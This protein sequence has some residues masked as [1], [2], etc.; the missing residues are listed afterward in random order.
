MSPTATGMAI[1]AVLALTWIILGFWACF[2]VGLAIALGAGIGRFVE[3][4]LDVRALS[5]ALRGRRYP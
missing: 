5:D 1:G 3:G 2:F 4:K